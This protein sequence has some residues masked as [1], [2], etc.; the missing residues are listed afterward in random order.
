[1]LGYDLRC[2]VWVAPIESI[3]ILTTVPKLSLGTTE[4]IEV[5][6]FDDGNNVFSSLA[7]LRFDWTAPKRDIL[8]V[9]P[10]TLTNVAGTDAQVEMER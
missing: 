4:K 7:G 8:T 10:L 6:A 2:E 1:M 9:L 3:V 5:Q